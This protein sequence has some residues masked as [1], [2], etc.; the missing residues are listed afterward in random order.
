[1]SDR[2][3]LRVVTPSRLMLEQ[4]VEEITAPGTVGDFGVLP[5][6]ITFLGSLETGTF[7][8]RTGSET[9]L[10]AIR[11]GFAEV[12]DNVMTVLANE[13]AFPEDVDIEQAR[14]EMRNAES[15]LDGMSTA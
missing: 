14:D 10:M 6:H 12:S 4:D 9:K 1:M 11:G 15:A 8:F 5:D 13:A 2:F 3:Q 7:R